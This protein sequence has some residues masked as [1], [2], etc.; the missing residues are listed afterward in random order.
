MIMEAYLVREATPVPK[1]GSV[2][3][4]TS[5][6]DGKMPRRMAVLALLVGRSE[7]E[8]VASEL[9]A[10]VEALRMVAPGAA[11]TPEAAIEGGA[12]NAPENVHRIIRAALRSSGSPSHADVVHRVS[13]R[14]CDEI[15]PRPA[16]LRTYPGRDISSVECE[17][18]PEQEQPISPGLQFQ[19]GLT[20]GHAFFPD[21]LH[22]SAGIQGYAH[23]LHVCSSGRGYPE[24]GPLKA[25][26]PL[27]LIQTI[28]KHRS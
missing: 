14:R 25:K 10:D 18:L 2:H 11:S 9:D 15:D 8:F 13:V 27:N 6:A 28:A 17:L 5:P 4:V 7:E 24:T 22:S 19:D 3:I 12:S 21:R 20:D 16:H 26:L 1:R 23:G